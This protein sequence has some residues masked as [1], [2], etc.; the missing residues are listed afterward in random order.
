MTRRRQDED[1]DLEQ[2]IGGNDAGFGDLQVGEAEG[3]EGKIAAAKRGIQE[4]FSTAA[5][6]NPWRKVGEAAAALLEAARHAIDQVGTRKSAQ[7]AADVEKTL[8]EARLANAAAAEKEVD[9]EAAHVKLVGAKIDTAKK[10]A[11]VREELA[12]EG[13]H[14][15]L[16]PDEHDQI[17]VLVRRGKTDPDSE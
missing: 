6:S 17:T 3:S 2:L 1:Q 9:A 12:R 15:D 13:I 11:E 10:V 4:G 16:L 14:L 7:M 5:G 8:A